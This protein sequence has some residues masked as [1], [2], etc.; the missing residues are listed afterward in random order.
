M[1]RVMHFGTSSTDIFAANILA[2]TDT[3]GG[4]TVQLTEWGKTRDMK[5]GHVSVCGAVVLWLLLLIAQLH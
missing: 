2:N 5:D 1:W 3:D 4:G